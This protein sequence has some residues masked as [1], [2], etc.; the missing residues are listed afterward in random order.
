MTTHQAIALQGITPNFSH[1]STALQGFFVD[2][3]SPPN[4]PQPSH[5]ISFAQYLWA[6]Q[7]KAFFT[8]LQD[9]LIA[10]PDTPNIYLL[11]T[12][13]SEGVAHL[14]QVP[15]ALPETLTIT[16]AAMT[17]FFIKKGDTL[18]RIE[19]T[20]KYSTGAAV[21]L[22]GASQVQFIYKHKQQSQ[23]T[24]KTGTIVDAAQGKVAY[25]WIAGDTATTGDYQAEWQITFSGGGILTIPNDGTFIEFRIV[26]SL[27]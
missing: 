24:I 16:T 27:D 9:G 4:P 17:D 10:I 2:V 11:G 19:S 20:L 7:T 3:V 26:P 22:T 14:T 13:T 23:V 18:P 21:N 8:S 25:S 1:K 6:L 12:T 15:Q 5:N